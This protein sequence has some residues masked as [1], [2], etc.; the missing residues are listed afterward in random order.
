MKNLSVPE[1]SK[2][3]TTAVVEEVV[4]IDPKAV[5]EIIDDYHALAAKCEKLYKLK[6]NKHVG[7]LHISLHTLK[8]LINKL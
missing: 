5:Q 1:K 2:V 3:K 4:V 6:S 7:D 8:T